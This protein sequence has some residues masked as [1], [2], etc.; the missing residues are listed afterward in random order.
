MA[1]IDENA[2]SGL[3]SAAMLSAAAP[4]GNSNDEANLPKVSLVDDNAGLRRMVGAMFPPVGLLAAEYEDGRAFLDAYCVREPGCVLLDV[5]MPGLDGLQVLARLREFAYSPP[6]IMMSG[7]ADVALAV[8]AMK[9]G[10]FDFLI[11]PFSR[12]QVQDVVIAAI[13][14]DERLREQWQQRRDV[15]GKLDQLKD[16]E[17]IV[18][19]H[20]VDGLL[21]K[22]IAA[23]LD[24][25]RRTVELRR[26]SI[27]TKLGVT[28]VGELMQLVYSARHTVDVSADQERRTA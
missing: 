10:A 18:L 21:T 15:Q 6:V 9:M 22:Q 7:A 12:R 1:G 17:R 19:N 23:R 5:R 20:V 3:G 8:E 4:I 14:L 25:S 13:R 28:N 26:A 2:A 11:K 16:E 24:V 27:L